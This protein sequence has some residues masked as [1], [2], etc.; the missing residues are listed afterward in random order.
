MYI[1]LLLSTSSLYFCSFSARR[2]KAIVTKISKQMRLLSLNFISYFTRILIQLTECLSLRLIFP[3][4]VPTITTRSISW[5]TLLLDTCT[6]RKRNETKP[7]K[8]TEQ[9]VVFV[10]EELDYWWCTITHWLGDVFCP[11]LLVVCILE[12]YGIVSH[13]HMS[14]ENDSFN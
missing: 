1:Y 11:G 5:W 10:M 14:G 7:W 12:L 9:H 3:W 8:C 13:F 2:M 6:S 4:R